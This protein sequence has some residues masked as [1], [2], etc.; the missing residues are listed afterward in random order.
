M[1]IL[2]SCTVSIMRKNRTCRSCLW[3]GVCLDS[4]RGSEIARTAFWCKAYV[5]R[6]HFRMSERYIRN[7][8]TEGRRRL[9]HEIDQDP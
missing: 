6:K 8:I 5:N 3:H 4:L 9:E 7:L 1:S 2:K